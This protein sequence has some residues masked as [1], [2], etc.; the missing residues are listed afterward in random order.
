MTLY[1]KLDAVLNW[2]MYGLVNDKVK[3]L[4]IREVIRI[5]AND[6]DNREV[7]LIYTMLLDGDYI[8]RNPND[9]YGEPHFITHKGKEFILAGGY[10]KQNER[11]ALDDQIQKGTVESFK[12]GKL[13]FWISVL[14]LIVACIALIKS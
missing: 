13:A 5:V 1:Q 14:S 9:P 12:Y 2:L 3:K 4:K 7:E 10:Q 8:A 11:R 6:V